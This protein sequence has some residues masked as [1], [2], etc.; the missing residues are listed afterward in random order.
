MKKAFSPTMDSLYEMLS[1]VVNQIVAAGFDDSIIPKIELATEEALVNVIHYSGLGE[2][3][4]IEIECSGEDGEGIIILIKDKGVP[5]NPIGQVK[6]ID[7]NL[8]IEE[9]QI[10]GY[11]IFLITKIMDKVEYQRQENTNVLSLKKYLKPQVKSQAI[12]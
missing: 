12:S 7:T 9:R 8:P 4:K 2:Q 6:E 1:F 10:G 5:Y 11:G 3:D